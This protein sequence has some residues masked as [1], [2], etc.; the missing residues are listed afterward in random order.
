MSK[1]DITVRALVGYLCFRY[2]IEIN[3]EAQ[4][5]AFFI[6]HLQDLGISQPVNVWS[7]KSFQSEF[8]KEAAHDLERDTIE[9]NKSLK[10]LGVS[11]DPLICN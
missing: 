6:K 3:A 7:D 2:N 1:V 5:T 8:F 4:N 10:K 9:L 11:I